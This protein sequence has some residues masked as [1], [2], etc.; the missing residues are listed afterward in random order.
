[1]PTSRPTRRPRWWSQMARDDLTFSDL[2]FI[3]QRTGVQNWTD[4]GTGKRGQVVSA[5]SKWRGQR[6]EMG[7]VV[8]ATRHHTG[9]SEDFRAAE[10]YPTYEVVKNGRAGLDNS[11]SAY[12]LGRWY[13]IY[14]FSEFLS[15]HA[16]AWSY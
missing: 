9:T 11:L 15:W 6:G 4:P 3:A 14:V 7:T 10:D 8:G 13:A 2:I 16:G 12:G 1:M 5:P